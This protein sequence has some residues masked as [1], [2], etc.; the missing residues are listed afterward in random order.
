MHS[1]QR[2]ADM[3]FW[4]VWTDPAL[5]WFADNGLVGLGLLTFT[6]AFIQPIPPDLLVLPMA[7]SANDPARLTLI[8]LVVTLSSVLGSL[9]AWW[10][11]ER[12]GKPLLDRF[13]KPST[14]RRFDTL[15]TRYGAFGVFIA[16]LSPIP[17]KVLGWCAG[18]GGM[19]RRHRVVCWD[20]RHGP[21]TVHRRRS[22]G[23]KPQVRCG[24]A[25]RGSL[26]RPA[27]RVP[28]RAGVHGGQS[29]RRIA[30]LA[31]MALVERAR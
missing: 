7:A 2:A 19:D 27:A 15:V 1:S 3:A 24:G 20:R 16:A 25:A 17:Y 8:F 31:R 5:A 22:G 6:E 26:R 14:V 9:V 10:M 23:P 21:P 28:Q 12:W 29:N 13:A 30:R 4:T 18:I 11:G